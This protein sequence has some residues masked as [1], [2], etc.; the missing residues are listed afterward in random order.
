MEAKQNNPLTCSGDDLSTTSLLPFPRADPFSWLLDLDQLDAELLR[1][2]QSSSSRRPIFKD[3]ERENEVMGR[4][5][6]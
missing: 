1:S 4:L 2:S 3:F 6:C 5:I